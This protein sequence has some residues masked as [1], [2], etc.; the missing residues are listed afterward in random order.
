MSVAAIV[1]LAVIVANLADFE[2][3]TPR[4]SLLNANDQSSWSHLATAAT[5]AVGAVIAILAT[6]RTER[7]RALWGAVAIVQAVLFVVEV[8]SV[9]VVVDS[10][11]YGKLIYVPLLA[12]LVVCLWR[13]AMASDETPL[14]RAAIIVLMLSYAVHVFGAR[15]VEAL[16]WGAGSWVYQVK[17]GFKGGAEL[18][19]WLLLVLA[20]ARLARSSRAPRSGLDLRLVRGGKLTRWTIG[21]RTRRG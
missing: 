18:G 13:L 21:T 1:T 14:V 15:V 4:V 9:H 16:G 11:S 10:H 8:S 19:G 17:V 6:L 3:D 5:L 2:L 12:A 20:L 7:A